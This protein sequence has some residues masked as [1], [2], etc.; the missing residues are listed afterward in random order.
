VKVL[1]RNPRRELE[2]QGPLRVA[3][4]LERLGINR[5]SV[6]VIREDTLVPGDAM[7]DDADT[8]EVRPV[9]SGGAD[10]RAPE[11]GG[12]GRAPESGGLG[13]A[14]ESGGQA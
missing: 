14:P 7:L 6:L 1:L 13:R 11:S 5:E 8:I 2:L 3:V 9:I 4:L 12:L 10:G